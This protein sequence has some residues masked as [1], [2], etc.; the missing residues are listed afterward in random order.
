M[1][2]TAILIS[3]IATIVA[4]SPVSI[5]K[6]IPTSYDITNFVA[7]CS[8]SGSCRCV[9]FGFFYTFFLY[10]SFELVFRVANLL[11]F[12]H[13]PYSWSFTFVAPPSTALVTCTRTAASGAG[14][15]FPQTSS[16]FTC[17]DSS[18]FAVFSKTLSNFRLVITD[19]RPPATSGGSKVILAS[20]CPI[21]TDSTGTYQTYTGP[22]SFSFTPL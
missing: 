1:K 20:D 4:A 15:T 16:F 7:G 9:P 17:S 8:P 5:E 6:R 22:T 2:Y 21:V 18:V 14:N 11:A 3:A 13:G 10:R 12:L 19:A